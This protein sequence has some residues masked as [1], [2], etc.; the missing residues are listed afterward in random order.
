MLIP[1]QSAVKV[2]RNGT[3]ALI[4]ALA[5]VVALAAWLQPS[6]IAVVQAQERTV[7][8]GLTL[9]ALDT[10][11]RRV[12]DLEAAQ[13]AA[14]LILSQTE[15]GLIAIGEYDASPEEPKTFSTIDE[16]QQEVRSVIQRMR[17][18]L[19]EP[20]E[21]EPARGGL[22]QM[23]TRY[24]SY[25]EQLNAPAGSTLVLLSA[26]SY[27]DPENT[28]PATVAVLANSFA[29][30]GIR[31]EGVSLATTSAADRAI[32]EALAGGTDGAYYDLGFNDGVL[33]FLNVT[34][35][36]DLRETYSGDAAGS[37]ALTAALDVLP[38]STTLVAGFVFDGDEITTALVSPSGQELTTGSTTVDVLSASGI[39]VYTVQDPEP[40]SWGMSSV[41]GTGSVLFVS[42]ILN[43][44]ALGPAEMPPAP[45][46]REWTLVAQSTADGQPH[47]DTSASLVAEITGP[48]G[49]SSAYELLDDGMGRDRLAN[50]GIYVA[51]ID[52]AAVPGVWDISLTMSWPTTPATIGLATQF[53]LEPFPE[54][55]LVNIPDDFGAGGT[56][57]TLGFVEVSLEGAPFNVG[58]E[59]I[60]VQATDVST[61][62]ALVAGVQADGGTAGGASRFRIVADLLESAN[63]E[64]VATLNASYFGREF[65]YEAGAATVNAELRSPSVLSRWPLILAGLVLLAAVGGGSAW[66]FLYR[67][68]PRGFI[69]KVDPEVPQELVVTFG[70]TEAALLDQLLRGNVVPATTLAGF[71]VRGGAFVFSRAGVAFRYNPERDGNVGMTI[72]GE[73]LTSG[74][75]P[76]PDGAELIAGGVAYQYTEE[77]LK[78]DIR[79]STLLKPED[80]VESEELS[81]FTNDPMTFDAPSS[82]RPTRRI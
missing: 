22:N 10:T 66:W 12:R 42:E 53:V 82:I 65:V 67:V 49:S 44:I 58:V 47:I 25:M 7:S 75:N 80:T 52:A 50:D 34:L 54:A 20:L 59:D 40:G 46:G 8:D 17:E 38:H 61:G 9:I 28:T 79:V 74:D 15:R 73:P 64:L 19:A 70:S 30:S 29:G 35:G 57:T 56:D 27:D 48:G 6:G 31:V 45:V 5:L 62:G 21:G 1:S 3:T 16:A 39:H 63:L 69:Y 71:P 32:I 33:R 24:A 72:N 41:G 2:K 18:A 23:L 77:E 68:P 51:Q 4:A 11:M 37:A 78:G 26:G 43:P 81:R 55:S 14:T 76:V 36:V 13:M 60:A